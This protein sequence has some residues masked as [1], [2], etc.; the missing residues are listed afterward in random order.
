MTHNDFH[1][2]AMLDELDQARR[3]VGDKSFI[4]RVMLR[5]SDRMRKK[6]RIRAQ[7]D[8]Y[9]KKSSGFLACNSDHDSS[10][11]SSIDRRPFNRVDVSTDNSNALGMIRTT[12]AQIPGAYPRSRPK[13][14]APIE[15][16]KTNQ[17]QGEHE[18]EE[19]SKVESKKE[20]IMTK[21]RS[22][23]TNDIHSYDNT[24][25]VEKPKTSRSAEMI[26]EKKNNISQPVL[27][28]L[29]SSTDMLVS[30]PAAVVSNINMSI[31]ASDKSEIS[32]RHVRTSADSYTSATYNPAMR[33]LTKGKKGGNPKNKFDVQKTPT[34][35]PRS[36]V[37]LGLQASVFEYPSTD[38]LTGEKFDDSSSLLNEID[39]EFEKR[40]TLHSVESDDA[41]FTA[42]AE[43]SPSVYNNNFQS[44]QSDEPIYRNV[45]VT[46]NNSDSN[47]LNITNPGVTRRT[48]NYRRGS[49]K[50]LSDPLID[51]W[52]EAT[53]DDRTGSS[54]RSIP[55]TPTDYVNVKGPQNIH[56]D[57]DDSYVN[58]TS[59]L[60][61]RKKHIPTPLRIKN[62]NNDFAQYDDQDSIYHAVPGLDGDS[63]HSSA[64]GS[65]E[66]VNAGRLN[67]RMSTEYWNILSPS[68]S[69]RIKDSRLNYVLVGKQDTFMHP[70]SPKR[71][72]PKSPIETFDKTNYTTIDAN[73]MVAL[74]KTM[75]SHAQQREK[76]AGLK[77]PK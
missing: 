2:S 30:K 34:P 23:T 7:S 47:T 51:K 46:R 22:M 56:S 1:G 58:V 65:Y 71:H 68:T 49:T 72:T 6:K 19:A 9:R 41:F 50:H 17:T 33:V 75:D 36:P 31:P 67:T 35:P 24:L 11:F 8:A 20:K 48:N 66:N 21:P 4:R 42:S 38:D 74:K 37:S 29:S 13:P 77:T 70:I 76:N 3:N 25:E 28:K 64:N 53:G 43:S 32:D 73:A 59:E 39:R 16:N 54:L 60:S 15:Q 55:F 69:G 27:K 57:D 14:L 44:K 45:E 40:I 61:K 62:K 63:A 5:A 52:T 26:A 18:A 10:I 12:S